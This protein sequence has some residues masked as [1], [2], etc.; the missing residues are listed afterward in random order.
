VV[1]A[2]ADLASSIF[3]SQGTTTL[4]PCIL[5]RA[6]VGFTESSTARARGVSVSFL[7]VGVHRCGNLGVRVPILRK[8]NCNFGR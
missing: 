2:E 7:F 3:L 6:R 4:S 1:D 5:A 8:W